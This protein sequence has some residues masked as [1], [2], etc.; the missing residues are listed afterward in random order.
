MNN[1]FKMLSAGNKKLNID[2]NTLKDAHEQLKSGLSLPLY[3]S[4][5]LSIY[6]YLW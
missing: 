4:I 3:L 5:Y 2:Y 1:N 6:L